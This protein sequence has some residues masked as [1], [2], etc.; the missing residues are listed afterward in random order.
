MH[1]FFFFFC[2]FKG[3]GV[4]DSSHKANQ[5]KEKKKDKSLCDT[6]GLGFSCCMKEI[7]AICVSKRLKKGF[8]NV[9]GKL[10]ADESKS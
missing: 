7:R 8:S 10:R 4:L 2:I 9:L 1:S 3:N 6:A 5:I